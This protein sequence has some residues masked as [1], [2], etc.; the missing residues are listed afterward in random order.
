MAACTFWAA[1]FKADVGNYDC[2]WCDRVLVPKISKSAANPG[3][4]FVSC[5]KDFGGCGL[6]SF[7]DAP[8]NEKFNPNKKQGFK[9]TKGEDDADA[10]RP[11]GSNIVGPIVNAPNVTETRLADLAAEVAGLRSELKL[12]LAY[13]KEVNNE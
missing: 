2:P 13:I 5:S 4:T 9:R 6:F 7:L 1:R 8:P 11:G 10:P 12:V 3:K